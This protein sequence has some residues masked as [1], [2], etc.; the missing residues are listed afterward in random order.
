VVGVLAAG[1]FVAF[2]GAGSCAQTKQFIGGAPT[3]SLLSI[4]GVLRRPPTSADT[5][6]PNAKHLLT[7]TARLSGREIFSNYIR[8]ARVVDGVPYYVM[9]VMFTGCGPLRPGPESMTIWDAGGYVGAGTAAVIERGLSTPGTGTFGS[10]TIDMLIPDG[11]AT[12]T[13]HYPAGTIGGF[14]RKHAPPLTITTTVVGNLIVV[15]VPRAGN[16]LNAP[17]TMTWRATNGTVVKTF[18]RL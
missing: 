12:A 8:R 15:T 6:P 11:V 16:R 13:L 18:S 10:S 1:S 4:L 7:V 14:D 2:A 17:M 5:L 3:Q 9:P